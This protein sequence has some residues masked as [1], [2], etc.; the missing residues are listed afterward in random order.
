MAA[1]KDGHGD[2]NFKVDPEL[3]RQ[4]K[5]VAAAKGMLMK[6]LLKASFDCWGERHAD[7]FALAP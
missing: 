3:R 4:F 5:L 7:E 6:D 1:K 2:L